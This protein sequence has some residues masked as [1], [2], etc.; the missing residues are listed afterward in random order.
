MQTDLDKFPRVKEAFEATKARL[1][2]AR[3]YA[4]LHGSNA[5]LINFEVG[6]ELQHLGLHELAEANDLCA[7]AVIKTL[8]TQGIAQEEVR[9][10]GRFLIEDSNVILKDFFRDLGDDNAGG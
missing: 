6:R 4:V 1:G 7:Q 10:F 9:T 5:L 2:E 3:A 8:V